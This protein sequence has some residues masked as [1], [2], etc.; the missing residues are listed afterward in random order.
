MFPSTPN[1]SLGLEFEPIEKGAFERQVALEEKQE[2]IA[3][4]LAGQQTWQ[5]LVL[6]QRALNQALADAFTSGSP[7]QQ[8]TITTLLNN[9]AAMKTA[10][11]VYRHT[12][13]KQGNHL[14]ASATA[15]SSTLQKLAQSTKLP[16][17]VHNSVRRVLT[18]LAEKVPEL[19]VTP[20]I[21]TRRLALA[22]HANI[23]TM[24]SQT[25]SENVVRQEGPGLRPTPSLQS[26]ESLSKPSRQHP[27]KNNSRPTGAYL[28]LKVDNTSMP[29]NREVARGIAEPSPQITLPLAVRRI[30]SVQIQKAARSIA[31]VS[32]FLPQKSGY[33]FLQKAVVAPKAI[34]PLLSN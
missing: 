28:V 12:R 24:V 5:H 30:V 32:E 10:V 27:S 23:S 3:D 15:F 14:V 22:P 11:A 9:V 25:S 4:V 6:L 26:A 33:Q 8:A 19:A 13:N 16:L 18:W 17:Q 21:S 7:D 34:S 2:R 1:L 29:Q 20:K 31:K